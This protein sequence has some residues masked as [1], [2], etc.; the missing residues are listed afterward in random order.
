MYYGQLLLRNRND[1]IAHNGHLDWTI[2]LSGH[3][4]ISRVCADHLCCYNHI[5]RSFFN[6]CSVKEVVYYN[7]NHGSNISYETVISSN[8]VYG[9]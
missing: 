3:G 2:V 6:F 4:N 8:S 9:K 1:V 7:L 5:F